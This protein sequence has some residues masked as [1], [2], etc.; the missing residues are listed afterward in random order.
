MRRSKPYFIL[1]AVLVAALIGF[2]FHL[3]AAGR[4]GGGG[5]FSGGSFRGGG[6]YVEG[7]RGGVAVRGPEG[8]TA[9]KTPDGAVRAEGSG[10]G[11][12]ARGPGG[13]AAVEG[14]GGGTAVR[15]PGGGVVAKGPEGG[16]AVK[17]PDGTVIA[18][19]SRPAND[20][21]HFYSPAWDNAV[22]A[23]GASGAMSFTDTLPDNV[24]TVV[25][26]GQTYYVSN[27]VYYQECMMG[28]DVLYCVVAPP[29]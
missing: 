14:P 4:G 23:S 2:P 26:D 1:S 29:K 6:G 21:D 5:G 10:G 18:G 17:T 12:F 15:G 9:V 8:G 19:G 13:G 16:V 22:A 28:S 11:E 7:P 20:W 25:V 27:G 24:T 3:Q